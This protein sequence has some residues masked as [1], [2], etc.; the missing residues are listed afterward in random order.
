VTGRSGSSL[1]LVISGGSAVATATSGPS[2]DS[3]ASAAGGRGGDTH[4]AGSGEGQVRSGDGGA[5]TGAGLSG[6]T[7]N[8]TAIL[9]TPYDG[10][11]GTRSGHTGNVRAF[12]RG[13]DA[14]C[15]SRGIDPAAACRPPLAPASPAGGT[16]GQAAVEGGVGSTTGSPDSSSAPSGATGSQKPAD[17]VPA[18]ARS[19]ADAPS[20]AAGSAPDVTVDVRSRGSA[21]VTCVAEASSRTCR[22]A[23]TPPVRAGD[24]VAGG[25]DRG[26]VTVT[27]LDSSGSGHGGVQPA[28]SS[29]TPVSRS[30]PLT[31]ASGPSVLALLINAA[32][33]VLAL[34]SLVAMVLTSRRRRA[35]RVPQ[36]IGKHRRKQPLP[37]VSTRHR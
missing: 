34:L 19:A 4:A 35:L 1:S 32:V 26:E 15:A 28:G 9:V 30:A 8:A 20:R 31:K 10:T 23:D 5:G 6:D 27:R 29:G 14:G 16:G 17:D 22:S 36:H 21:D 2:G 18:A 11:A 12:A 7:G 25:A 33:P 3:N 37:S 13:G 24:S